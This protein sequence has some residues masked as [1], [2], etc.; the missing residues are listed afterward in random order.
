MRL[1]V[2]A[3]ILLAFQ[4]RAQAPVNLALNRPVRTS[5]ATWPGMPG[6]AINDGSTTTISHPLTDSGTLGF[7]FQ[8]DLGR[9]YRLDRIV[10]RNREDGCC[11]ERL[12]RY[13]IEV[14]E[15][16][17]GDPGRRSWNGA[18]RS[19]GSDSGVGGTDVVT[20]SFDSAGNFFGRFVRIV[21][22]SGAA[23]SP[24]LSE[25]EVYG[26]QPPVVRSFTAEP[27]VVSPGTPVTLRWNV[28]RATQV[29]IDPGPGLVAA[30][31]GS[32]VVRPV[33]TTTYLLVATNETGSVQAT[34]SIGVGIQLAPPRISEIVPSNSG[35]LRDEDGDAPD[36]IE[37]SNPNPYSFDVA[38]LYLTDAP[39]NRRKWR[40]PSTRIPPGGFLVVFAS[41]KDRTNPTAPLHTNFRLDADGDYLALVAADGATVL[42][43]IPVGHPQQAAFPPVP[44]NIAYG[45]DANGTVGFMRPPTPGETN[46][47][48]YAGIVAEPTFSRSRGF[49]D[50]AFDLT[51]STTTPGAVI[52]YTTNTATPTANTGTV[53]SGPIPV[54]RNTVIRAAAFR[55]GWAPTRVVTAT[56]LFPDQIINSP[57]MRTAITRDPVYAPK[58]RA[59]LT[60][61]P[62]VSL[63]SP[64]AYNDL[65]EEPTSVE[66]IDPSN[67]AGFQ[68]DCGVRKFGG[69]FTDFAKDNFRLYFRS[70][71]GATKL[72]FP[73]FAGQDHGLRPADEFD[74]LELRGGSHDMVERGF[75]LS[76]IFTDDTQLDLG[77]L[78]AHGRFVH[79]CINGTY[80]GLYHL[81]ERWG[82]SMHAEYLGGS[83]EDYES[84]N[85]NYNVG[86]WAEPG[87]PYDGDG[88]IWA[89]VRDVRSSYA[90]V[91]PWVDLPHYTDYMLTFLF[92][93]S[94]DEYRAVGPNVPGTGFKFFLNDSDGWLCVPNY[95]ASG[96][97]TARGAP[98]R[99]GGDGPGSLF[100]TLLKEGNPDFRTL[101]A[102][103]FHRALHHDGAL[104]P[105]RNAA[106]L[107]ARTE[108]IERAFIAEAARWGYL[109]PSD[110]AARRDHVLQTW[111]PG[112][113][114]EAIAT[115]RNA[116]MLPRLDAP[117]S[118]PHGGLVAIGSRVQFA[119]PPGSQVFYTLDGSDPRLPGG[120]PNPGAF[121]YRSGTVSVPLIASGSRWR[122]FTDATGLGSS[123][124]VDGAP[125]WSS[126]NWKHPEFT[127]A[128]WSEGPAQ[129]GYGEGDE[130]TLLPF[131][132]N[133]SSKW[134][135]AYFRHRFDLSAT[136]GMRS[137]TLRLLRDDGA[138]VYLNGR[139]VARS[140]IREGPVVGATTADGAPDDGQT[141]TTF[142]LSSEALRTG[143]NLLAV[144]LHQAAPTSSDASFDLELAALRDANTDGNPELVLDRNTLVRARARSG[145]E[146]SALD[147]AFFRT[148]AAVPPGSIVFSEIHPL[149]AGDPEVEYVELANVSDQAVN[150]R[151]ARFTE[152]IEFAFPDNRDTLLASG[153]RLVLVRDALHFLQR[154]GRETPIAGIYSGRLADQG[155]LL[156]LAD[157]DGNLIFAC[158]YSTAAPWP[159]VHGGLSLVLV[160]PALDANRPDSWR[161]SLAPDGTPGGTDSV[162]FDGDPL[163]DADHDGVPSILE[164]LHGTSDSDPT[165]GPG[166][167]EAS[168]AGQAWFT[169]SFPR[170]L[171]T[172]S[173]RAFVESSTDLRTW[174]RATQLSADP[175]INGIRRE[176]WGTPTAGRPS[177]FLR[178]R[179]EW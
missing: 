49:V 89:H 86:G 139:E 96:D 50:N 10:V 150:L 84:I 75:Y 131:G 45:R 76:N 69:A 33:A 90:E 51:L 60:D 93:G 52:R 142:E 109:S 57:V 118:L 1:L 42:D 172:D 80:W 67:P 168:P 127:D 177:L 176:T 81:R 72:R 56:Y 71:F 173:A 9:N 5:A 162:P 44:S 132:P 103:R 32:I 102:D 34:A 160:D 167:M 73:L 161:A 91:A 170:R 94:E 7:H 126:S 95:C 144:E 140:S 97:R 74:Q 79:V 143:S 22:R 100:S 35:G 19:D 175:P 114:A 104:T 156:S 137:L 147:E 4:A 164:Y 122:W 29:R 159:S 18:V 101:V 112:R 115:F 111:F 128:S 108:P 152:G 154:H 39:S 87:T 36:W 70:E 146:W 138:I 105:A 157:P 61:L 17:G 26:T 116:G 123:T 171:G 54:T 149:P 119:A 110:W 151:G 130:K 27:D 23:Y 41:G 30:T 174:N 12:S 2:L 6:G 28:E 113:T 155:E 83:S 178:L 11:T 13:A 64:T 106:R 3:C 166:L 78:G 158:Q 14:Y 124:L 136:N 179:A 148:E 117:S 58:L 62:T 121:Q 135:T 125:G 38:G 129:L 25:I 92:G 55:E 53:Y 31:N 141:F 99:Q 107:R 40:L 15:D 153:Q 16:S 24:Q 169:L 133:A 163:A 37:L 46:G 21:N 63:V 145:T 77:Q 98:G 82:A 134:V 65:R 20:A 59:A 88:S 43:Q 85:G 120:L 47:T 68:E 66:W 8:V 165:A 48:A